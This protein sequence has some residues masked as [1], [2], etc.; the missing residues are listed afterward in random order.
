[1]FYCSFMLIFAG[2]TVAIGKI[3][4]IIEVDS[5]PQAAAADTQ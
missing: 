1:M 5:E 3:M 2:K 4:K